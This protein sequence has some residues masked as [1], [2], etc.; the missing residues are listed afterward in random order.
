MPGDERPSRDGFAG[1][2]AFGP[3][4][5]SPTSPARSRRCGRPRRRPIRARHNRQARVRREPGGRALGARGDLGGQAALAADHRQAFR[6][7]PR[8]QSFSTA[9]G[10]HIK[11]PAPSARRSPAGTCAISPTIWNGDMLAPIA[12]TLP[13]REAAGRWRVIC[14]DP[15]RPMLAESGACC[16]HNEPTTWARTGAERASRKPTTGSRQADR[17]SAK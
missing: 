16:C 12:E 1:T 14:L 9:I 2:S 13:E 3:P 6:A 8:T 4:E 10:T 17:M 11:N 7:S 5:E 15:I